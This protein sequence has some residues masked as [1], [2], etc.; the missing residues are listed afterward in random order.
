MRHGSGLP[1]PCHGLAHGHGLAAIAAVTD[2]M[3]VVRPPCPCNPEL[4]SLRATAQH[5]DVRPSD[6]RDSCSAS[7]RVLSRS[8]TVITGRPEPPS[9][10]S[11]HCAA[12]LP[13]SIASCAVCTARDAGSL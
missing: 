9:R 4:A 2:A 3:H 13:V 10:A 8:L 11:V 1:D 12:C 7:A 6:D 5:M